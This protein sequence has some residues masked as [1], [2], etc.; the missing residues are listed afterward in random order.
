MVGLGSI[1][2]LPIYIT[3][4]PKTEIP[5]FLLIFKLYDLN[6]FIVHPLTPPLPL[7]TLIPIPHILPHHLVSSIWFNMSVVYKNYP[8]VCI[9][10]S[11]RLLKSC[12][13]KQ[14]IKIITH[15]IH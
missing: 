6:I 3:S 8:I 5:L 7:L 12:V 1:T 4:R 15:Q 11:I 10:S 14:K 2:G 9:A 13:K